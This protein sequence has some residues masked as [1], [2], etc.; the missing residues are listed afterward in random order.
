MTTWVVGNMII[1]LDMYKTKVFNKQVRLN[2]LIGV[3][4]FYIKTFRLAF[5]IFF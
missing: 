1:L 3:R 5:V 4:Q 2:Q